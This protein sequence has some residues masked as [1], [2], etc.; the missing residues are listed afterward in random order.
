M[1]IQDRIFVPLKRN[2]CTVIKTF[3]TVKTEYLYRSNG[4]FV[5]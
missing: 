1:K 3:C 5:P 4:V 2:I